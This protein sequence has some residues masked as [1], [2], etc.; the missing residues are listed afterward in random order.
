[1][2]RAADIIRARFGVDFYERESPLISTV[3]TTA[4]R[5]L[6]DNPDRLWWV[7]INLSLNRLYGGLTAQV[8]AT[9]ALFRLE[10][11]GGFASM[12]VDEDFALPTREVFVVADAAASALWV[13]E[14]IG[15]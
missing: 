8:S 2:G 15:R 9:R 4:D 10:Q 11:S 1:M 13:V 6:A 14:G 3:G 12:S 7:I 5:A